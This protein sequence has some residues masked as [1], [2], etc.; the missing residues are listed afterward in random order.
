MNLLAFRELAMG[1]QATRHWGIKDS[2]KLKP[3]EGKP[4]LDLPFRGFLRPS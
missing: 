1:D 2:D 3:T 4:Y